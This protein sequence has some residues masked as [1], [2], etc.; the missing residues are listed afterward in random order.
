MVTSQ[1]ITTS[2]LTYFFLFLLLFNEM[3]KFLQKK[4]LIVHVVASRIKPVS[5]PTF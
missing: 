1:N 5:L 3:E 2:L 4:V